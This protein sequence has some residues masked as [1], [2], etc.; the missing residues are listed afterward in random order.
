VQSVDVV[1]VG[2]G[3]AGAAVAAGFARAGR[4]V[5]LLDKRPLGETGARWV[6]L[7]PRWCFEE[8]GVELPG[9]EELFHDRPGTFVMV[10]PGGAASV[11]TRGAGRFFHVDMRRLVGRLVNE[12]LGLGARFEERRLVELELD[13]SGRPTHVVHERP[14]GG[15]RE[16][17]RTR[18]V[19][20]ASGLGG[21]VRERVPVLRAACLAPGPLDRCV[22]AQYQL[23][24]K[25]RGPLLSLLER[26]GAMPGDDL[27]F[28]ST[29]GGYSTLTITTHH[30]LDEVGVLAGSIPAMG[31]RD[32]GEMLARFRV[33]NPWLGAARFGGQAPIPV[34]RPFDR[35]SGPG[36]ALVGDAAC[37]VYASHG[38]GVGIGLIAARL[39]V[40]AVRSCDDPG[41]AK[42]L[43][44]YDERFRQQH[45]GLLAASDAFRRFSQRLAPETI[46]ALLGAG[47][48]DEGF[49]SRALEQ[50]PLR[51]SAAE[52]LALASRA[53]RAPAVAMRFAPTAAR[54][55]L[56]DR[57]GAI[58]S[59]AAQPLL[60]RAV[61]E[62]VGPS[63]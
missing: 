46:A 15:G 31:V 29:E 7:V 45:G 56:L 42:A 62:L 28:P 44:R 53:A 60:D 24:V 19:V 23:D 55:L 2:A 54:T 59:R 21:R 16:R 41:D 4:S 13:P 12:A 10:A 48:I 63:H 36:V 51:P 11:R 50:R 58:S 20:D 30:E 9:R 6:N 26:H 1:V 22:A 18:L 14:G 5:L 33:E 52:A 38:S 49:F 47:L 34:R 35:L 37:Q 43:A 25:D 61:R 27:A 32:G 17:V 40:E 39:L 3:S 8:A 57:L